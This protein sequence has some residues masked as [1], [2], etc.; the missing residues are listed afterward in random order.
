LKRISPGRLRWRLLIGNL[1]VAGAGAITVAAAV[2]LAAPRA[3]EDAMGSQGSMAGMDTMMDAAVSAAFG[4][5]VGSALVLGVGAATLV[6][7]V[8]AVIISARLARPISDLATASRQVAAGDYAQRVPEG[9]GEL[10]DLAASFNDMA[11][12]L[13]ATERRR[14]E[15]IGDV[16]HELRTPI[17]SLRGYVEG[18]DAGVFMPGP[19]AWRV[20]GDQ[21]SRLARLVDDLS[22][23]WRAEAL[24]MALVPE[25]LDGQAL[26]ED[27]VE[28]H[29]AAAIARSIELTA[30]VERPVRLWA[31]QARVAQV[32]D[33]L[34][35]N[36]LRYTRPGGRVRVG[37][38]A[39]GETVE[40]AVTDTGPGLAADQLA[41]VFERLYRVD[42]SRS[43]DEGGSGL[44]LAIA[45]AL[46]DLMSGRIWATSPGPGLGAT[47]TFALP[48]AGHSAAMPSRGGRTLPPTSR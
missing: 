13:E 17:A 42:P 27:A 40:I 33:N 21:A 20:L 43:R 8:V 34:V 15:L 41:R 9:S 39:R 16:A 1:L 29:R 23:L 46:T 2:S 7:V 25:D 38:V 18:L 37:I 6:A 28:R 12:S 4:D 44:G 35:G 26:I 32:L 30:A 31:D 36:A 5:A 10:G 3:F 22:D 19:E 24:D 48:A 14:H 45:R 11:A 47:F